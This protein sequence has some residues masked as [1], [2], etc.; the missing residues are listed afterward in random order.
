MRP[1]QQDTAKYALVT[2]PSSLL[3]LKKEEYVKTEPLV[4]ESSN[5]KNMGPDLVVRKTNKGKEKESVVI[6]SDDDMGFWDGIDDSAD[7]GQD[8]AKKRKNQRGSKGGS[9]K[10]RAVIGS[11]HWNISNA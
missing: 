10:K 6:D 1:L 7:T 2:P 8:S 5:D 4:K 11:A 3:V 9:A